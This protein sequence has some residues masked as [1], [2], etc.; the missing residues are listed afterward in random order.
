MSRRLLRALGHLVWAGVLLAGFVLSSYLAFNGFVRRG[1]VILPEV[2]GL[3]LDEAEARLATAGIAVRWQKERD[4]FDADVPPGKVVLQIPKGGTPAKRRSVVEVA[5][6]RGRELVE[7]PDLAGQPMP[8]VLVHLRAAGLTVGRSFGIYAPGG[9]EGVVVLQAPS[10]GA[11]VDPATPVDLFLRLA[12]TGESYVMPDLIYR[13]YD[14]VREFFER[15]GFRLGSVK[16]ELYEGVAPG[17][18]LRQHPLAGHRLRPRDVIS[19]VVADGR[20]VAEVG[21]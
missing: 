19:L 20:R 12:D 4:R 2:V 11:R 15:R 10:P 5:L 14:G 9:A 6:S 18:V 16:Y 8:T 13:Q 17:V 3:S 1:E 7:V 21:R